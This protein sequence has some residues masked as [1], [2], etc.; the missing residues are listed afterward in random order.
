MSFAQ[1]FAPRGQ[2]LPPVPLSPLPGVP[3]MRHSTS[4]SLQ[5]MPRA[6]EA[7]YCPGLQH[8]VPHCS[9]LPEAGAHLPSPTHRLHGL[10]QN[11]SQHPLLPHLPL[12]HDHSLGQQ[13]GKQASLAGEQYFHPSLDTRVSQMCCAR[14]SPARAREPV[15]WSE[16]PTIVAATTRIARRRGI[17]FANDRASSSRNSVIARKPSCRDCYR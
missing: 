4:P 10:Q 7:Q 8:S 12:Q 6:G 14:P 11:I 5:Q 1:H 17:G 13:V 2:H 3:R 15:L 16:A 9:R